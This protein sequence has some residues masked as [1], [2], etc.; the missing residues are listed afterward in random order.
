MHPPRLDM[1]S[2]SS[3]QEMEPSLSLSKARL[4]AFDE[5]S[6]KRHSFGGAHCGIPFGR[7]ARPHFPSPHGVLSTPPGLNS[8]PGTPPHFHFVP[9][10]ARAT[11]ETWP[12]LARVLGGDNW[13]TGIHFDVIARCPHPLVALG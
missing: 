3:E 6:A 12:H 1:M 10:T 5:K 9:E 2:P 4:C 13:G 7:S 11:A 8:K